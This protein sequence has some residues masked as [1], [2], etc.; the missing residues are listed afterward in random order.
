MFISKAEKELMHHEI[1]MLKIAASDAATKIAR[2]HKII[3]TLMTLTQE[4][5]KSLKKS[6]GWSPEKRKAQ[7]DRMKKKW[8]EKKTAKEK[9]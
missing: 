3:S 9:S 2:L 4:E 7:S 6:S 5:K 8:A 1:A